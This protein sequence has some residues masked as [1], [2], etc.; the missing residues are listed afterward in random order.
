MKT[1][2]LLIFLI[3]ASIFVQAQNFST[4]LDTA[5][6]LYKTGKLEE[7]HYSMLQMMQQLEREIAEQILKML[8]T[9][10]DSLNVVTEADEITGNTGFAGSSTSR[11]WGAGFPNASLEIKGNSPNI[12]LINQY[13]NNNAYGTGK[14]KLI[15][16]HGLKGKLTKD[17]IGENKMTEIQIDIPVGETLIRFTTVNISE[18]NTVKLINALPIPTIV[19]LVR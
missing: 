6:N 9:K 15:K 10:L 13:F 19:K 1:G 2:S 4:H 16:V 18:E 12:A 5:R 3:T 14:D 8:P 17:Q 11:T 7:S